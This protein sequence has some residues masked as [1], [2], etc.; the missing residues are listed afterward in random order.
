MAVITLGFSPC[1]NDTF[2]FD[3]LVNKKIETDGFTFEYSLA[4]VETLNNW[5]FQER[6]EITKIS[7]NAFL[8]AV[9]HYRLLDCG[10]ALGSGVGP[11]LISKSPLPDYKFIEE[12]VNS[13]RIAIPGENTTANLLLSLAFPNAKNKEE[14]LFSNIERGVLSGDFDLGLIIHETRFTYQE[15]GLNKWIDLGEWWERK[16]NSAIPL[17]GIVIRRDIDKTIAI[18]LQSLIKKSIEYSW[19]NYPQ[20]SAFV[21]DN[22]QEMNEEIMRKHIELYVNDFSDSLGIKGRS[23]IDQ[24]FQLAKENGVISEIPENIYLLNKK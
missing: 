8:K 17:G 1:P 3:A 5:A 6:L 19:S 12:V 22:A 14:V 15:K 10:S 18:E 4:D 24:L 9:D 11:L 2:I 21:K 13:S 23:A 7:Y 20:L 16:T